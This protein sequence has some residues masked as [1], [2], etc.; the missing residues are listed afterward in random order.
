MAVLDQLK[1]NKGTVSSLLGKKLARDVLA[2]QLEILQ[3][4]MGLVCYGAGSRKEKHVRAGA[5]KIVECVAMENPSLVA[6]FLESLLPALGVEEPQTKWMV[7]RTIGFCAAQQPGIA[8]KALPYAKKY[9]NEKVAGQLCLVGATD[10]FLGDYGEI[11]KETAK[12]V[13][14][15]LIESANNVILN[16]HDWLMEAFM[17]IA[18]Y[19]SKKEKEVIIAFARKYENH[20]RKKTQ[21]RVK[22][23]EELCV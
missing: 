4:A 16:E 15:I 18:K 13:Y 7:I 22:K 9:I 1:T 23:L 3:E 11:S 8:K 17:R 10:L 20:S 2:G 5:A 19:L 12:E 14:P 6:P 21:E